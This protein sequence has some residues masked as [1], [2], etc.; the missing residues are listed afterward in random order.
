MKIWYSCSLRGS[1]RKDCLV[2]QARDQRSRQKPTILRNNYKKRTFIIPK[3]GFIALGGGE[4]KT[5]KENR[6][7]SMHS[8]SGK[9]AAVDPDVKDWA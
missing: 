1:A 3:S 9:L 7:I 8:A 4:K 2:Y 5:K 6:G